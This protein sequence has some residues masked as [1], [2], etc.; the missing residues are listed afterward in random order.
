MDRI[1]TLGKSGG[2]VLYTSY[3]DNVDNVVPGGI[4]TVV[5]YNKQYEARS[6]A[7]SGGFGGGDEVFC[8]S[9]SATVAVAVGSLLLLL[10]LLL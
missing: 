7:D 6:T 2:Y 9:S 5:V 10:F 1:W 3:L 4:R 8:L